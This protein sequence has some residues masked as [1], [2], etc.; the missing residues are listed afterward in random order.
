MV[1]ACQAS[2]NNTDFFSQSTKLTTWITYMHYSYNTI[3]GPYARMKCDFTVASRAHISSF[4]S[5]YKETDLQLFFYTDSSTFH[6]KKYMLCRLVLS[7]WE[8]LA[9]FRQSVT[10]E[11]KSNTALSAFL[12]LKTGPKEKV[13]WKSFTGLFL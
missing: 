9:L 8:T 10:Y 1:P 2:V 7:W 3:I 5:T 12:K 11:K 6:L 4:G 13:P